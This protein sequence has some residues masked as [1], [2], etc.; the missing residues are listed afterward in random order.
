MKKGD[1]LRWF[2]PPVVEGDEE[3]R[4]RIVLMNG[5][6]NASLVFVL[7][8]FLGNLTNPSTPLRNYLIDLSLFAVFL[9]IRI[10][11]NRGWY[12]AAG[13]AASV[14][15]FII[16]LL[17]IVSDGTVRSTATFLLL[18]VISLSGILY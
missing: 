5:M 6:I 17:S 11:L 8:V 3:N 1:V 15:G 14:L 18:L 9:V 2:S 16:I 13:I 7:L 4:H 10:I 12:H